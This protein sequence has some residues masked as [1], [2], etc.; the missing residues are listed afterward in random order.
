[1]YWLVLLSILPLPEE[2]RARNV[3]PNC[4]WACIDAAVKVNKIESLFGKYREKWLATSGAIGPATNTAVQE[5]VKDTKHVFSADHNY[6]LLTYADTH[7]VVISFKPG[8]PGFGHHTVFLI[9]YGEYCYFY[10]SNDQ[11]VK[12]RKLSFIKEWWWGDALILLGDK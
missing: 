6:D 10:D 3:G 5:W 2:C 8:T 1:M 4:R 7:G 9:G 12:E 11:I